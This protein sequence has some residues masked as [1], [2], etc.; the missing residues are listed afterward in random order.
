MATGQN[1]IDG[2]GATLSIYKDGVRLTGDVQLNTSFSITPDAEIR[3]QQFTGEKRA[4]NDLNIRGYDFSLSFQLTNHA[5]AELADELNRLESDGRPNPNYEVILL[6]N[7]PENGIRSY[8]LYDEV[9]IIPPTM[10]GNEDEYLTASF[11][12][13]SRQM[14]A[15]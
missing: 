11:D 3:T 13:R 10:E 5:L 9:V 4:R 1:R 7:Y 15:A 6:L 2:K 14:A 12:G 8:T